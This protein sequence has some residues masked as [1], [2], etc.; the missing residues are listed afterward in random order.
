MKM[1]KAEQNKIG[2]RALQNSGGL[3]N[4]MLPEKTDKSSQWV[5]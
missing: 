2:K 3:G 1:E 4:E 5:R